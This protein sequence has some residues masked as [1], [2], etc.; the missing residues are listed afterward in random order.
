MTDR[1][2]NDFSSEF[3]YNNATRR[4]V[5]G[6]AISVAQNVGSGISSVFGNLG[7]STSTASHWPSGTTDVSI[8]Q[9]GNIGGAVG[10]IISAG[11]GIA[12]AMVNAGI[13]QDAINFNRSQYLREREVEADQYAISQLS[14]AP[15]I[16]IAPSAGCLRDFVGNTYLVYRYHPTATDTAR[17]DKLLTMYGYKDTVPLTADLFGNRTYFDYVRASGITIGGDIVMWKKALIS[18][19]LN[20]GVRVW[21]VKPN[22]SHYA[23]NPIKGA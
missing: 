9:G 3:D 8:S 17:I 7:T 23:D 20:T 19:Q 13:T 16:S 21:H 22:P 5:A 12:G 18:A 1:A 10:G 15:E 4:N 11:A 2:L 6:A 14:I